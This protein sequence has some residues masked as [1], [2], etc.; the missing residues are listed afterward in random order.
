MLVAHLTQG[1]YKSIIVYIDDWPPFSTALLDATEPGR[2]AAKITESGGLRRVTHRDQPVVHNARSGGV[3]GRTRCFR[4]SCPRWRS[5]PGQVTTLLANTSWANKPSGCATWRSGCWT[6]AVSAATWTSRADGASTHQVW[7][8]GLLGTALGTSAML[9]L[10]DA[11][12]HKR[13][14]AAR[15]GTLT[16]HEAHLELIC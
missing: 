2:S 11:R 7:L 15:S 16:H 14:P 9:R 1:L 8:L 4:K 5:Q 12:W 6:R 10:N 3:N 13:K